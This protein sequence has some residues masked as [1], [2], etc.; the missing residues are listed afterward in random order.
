[1][2]KS[3][4]AVAIMLAGALALA[5]GPAYASASGSIKSPFI[6]KAAGWF[7]AICATSIVTA[8]LIKNSAQNK[9]LSRN[10]ATSCGFQFWARPR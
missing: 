8:A 6:V 10:E 3:S 5:A 9:P 7:T 2:K 4:K 1:M